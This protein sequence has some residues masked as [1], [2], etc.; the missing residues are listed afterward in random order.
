[1]DS[2]E[3]NKILGAVLGACLAILTINI[4]AGSIFAP[5]K[6]AKPGYD[7]VV[8]DKPTGHEP[9]KPATPE[10]PIE[11]L[12]AKADVARG[13]NA[14]KKC[15][16]CHTF[17]KGGRPLVGPN[18]WGVVGRPKAHE[19]GF[20]YS[21]ALKAKGGNWT[22]DDLS[23][24]ISNPKAAVPGT[25]MTFA[26]VPKGSERA[27]IIAYLNS[28]SD[29]PAPLPTKA[30]EAPGTPKAAEAPAAPKEAPEAPKAQ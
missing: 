25:N 1:M 12:L 22:I 5:Q 11:E 29:N 20:N 14:A 23:Q 21:A 13:E 28:L 4:A 10:Q 24:F 27:D 16:A 15:A 26:G 19:A 17:N 8:P 18:L 6:L 2:F 9:A 7:I 30:A 3:M